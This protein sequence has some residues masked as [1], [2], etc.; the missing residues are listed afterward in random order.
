MKDNTFEDYAKEVSKAVEVQNQNMK[1]PEGNSRIFQYPE[2]VLLQKMKS[3]DSMSD[4]E[5]YELIKQE[6]LG[7]MEDI[8]KRKYNDYKFLLDSP[9]FLNLLIQVVK[10]GILQ[11]DTKV[12]C[13]AFI[14]K[15]IV[16]TE[17]G[18]YIKELLFTLGDYVNRYYSKKLMGWEIDE[19][20]AIFLA[21]AAHSA[22]DP[23]INIKRVNFTIATACPQ[24]MD[25]KTIIHIYEA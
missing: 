2:G 12:Y 20:L 5:A 21:V 24:N 13:N 22:F 15:Y 25:D 16:H 23:V 8:F 10:N 3:L 6:Y 4:Q 9:K 17:D 11:Y 18:S 19:K 7:L 1:V 14:Y